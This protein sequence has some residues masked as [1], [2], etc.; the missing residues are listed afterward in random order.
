MTTPSSLAVSRIRPK[1]PKDS[2]TRRIP[3]NLLSQP[4]IRSARSTLYFR[5]VSFR[6]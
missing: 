4:V 2:Q 6:D 5:V 3:D 1:P